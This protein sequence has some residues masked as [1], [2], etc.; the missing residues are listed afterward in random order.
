LPEARRSHFNER[1]AKALYR[2]RMHRPGPLEEAPAAFETTGAELVAGRLL[3]VHGTVAADGLD[4]V[5]VLARLAR[6]DGAAEW[7]TALLAGAGRVSAR[8]RR[9]TTLVMATPEGALDRPLPSPEYDGWGAELQWLWLLATATPPAAYVPAE[10]MG[11]DLAASAVALSAGWRALVLR[12]GAAF[13][14]EGPDMGT[15]YR[16][17]DDPELHFRSIYLDA[18]MLGEIQRQR[19]GEIADHLAGLGDPVR[20]PERLEEL[21]H[22]LAEFRNVYWWQHLGAQWHGSRL[23]RSYQRQHE[24]P[25]LYDQVVGELADYARSAQTAASQRTE[26]LLGI[27][28]VFGL[29]FGLAVGILHALEIPD[30]EWLVVSLAAATAVTVGLLLTA[31]GRQLVRLWRAV[32][33]RGR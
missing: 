25:E 24:L 17:S 16:L 11:D 4:V 6:V 20:H 13:L 12:D 32:G 3:A 31:P 26:A 5:D 9:A 10:E 19:L 7:Y 21:E 22:E 18:F 14:G 28:T 1:T 15:V 8:T 2:T 29:P 33:R 23:L 30:W 27:L